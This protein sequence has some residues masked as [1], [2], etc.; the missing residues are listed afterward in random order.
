M[1]LWGLAVL[2]ISVVSSSCNCRPAGG[3]ER[4]PDGGSF[5]EG[6][7]GSVPGDDGGDDGGEPR[8]DG[9]VADDDWAFLPPDFVEAFSRF[10]NLIAAPSPT[11]NEGVFCRGAEFDTLV[12]FGPAA[13]PHLM[14]IYAWGKDPYLDCVLEAMT[15]VQIRARPGFNWKE[16]DSGVMRL[17]LEWWEENRDDPRWSQ[18]GQE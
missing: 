5:D 18:P 15:G 17:W 16:G 7:A 9:G 8:V 10:S 11:A 14:S 13:V 1:R 6:D 2:V 4:L 12:A 3:S